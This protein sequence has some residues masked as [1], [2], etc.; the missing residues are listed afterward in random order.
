MRGERKAVQ[1]MWNQQSMWNQQWN[2]FAKVCRNAVDGTRSGNAHAIVAELPYGEY[3]S[4]NEPVGDAEFYVDTVERDNK[5]TNDQAFAEVELGSGRVKEVVV[6]KLDTG[7]QVNIIPKAVH[8]QLEKPRTGDL[9]V[10]LDPKDLNK[11][12]ARPHH[13][14]RTLEDILPVLTGAKYFSKLDARSAEITKPLRQLMAKDA[15]FLWDDAQHDAF[16]KVKEILTQSPVLAYFDPSKDTCL[17][18]DA[19]K[20]GL[21]AVVLQE[22]R[23]VAYASKS[24]T[25]TEVGYA[26]IEKELYAILFGCKRFHQYVYGKQTVV[27]TDHKPLTA[28]FSKPLHVAPPRLQRMLLQLQKYVRG[29]EIP[30]ADTLSRNFVSNT[31]PEFSDKLEVHVHTV[32]S[33]L[34]ISDVRLQEVKAATA[35]DAQCESLVQCIMTGWPRLRKDCSPSVVEFWNIRDE[36]TI[37]DGIIMKGHKIYIPSELRTRFLENIHA[38]HM[39]V[40]K[41]LSR[42]RDIVFWPRITAEITDMVLR[43]EVCLERRNS[44][45]KEPLTCHKVPEY[46]W[47]VVAS[48]LFTWEGSDY[49][50]VVDYYSRFFEVEKLTSTTSSCVINRLKRIF[51]RFG[52]PEKCVSDNGPQYAS[53]EF[54]RFAE[55]Y[56]FVHPTSSPHYPRSNG[57]AERTVQTVKRILSKAK[58]DGKDY[59]IGVLEYLTTPLSLG[60]SPSQLLMGRRLR[61]VVPTSAQLLKPST[62]DPSIVRQRIHDSQHKYKQYHDQSAQP[63]CPLGVGDGVRVQTGNGRWIPAVV[64]GKHDEHSYVVCTPDGA[65]YRRNRR[66]LVKPPLSAMYP[67]M[68]QNGDGPMQTSVSVDEKLLASYNPITS[69]PPTQISA[70]QPE[71]KKSVSSE[72]QNTRKEAEDLEDSTA[73]ELELEDEPSFKRRKN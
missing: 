22:G 4:E 36:L 34:P 26:Q 73:T 49:L 54:A 6:F 58:A 9:R 5:V 53:Q 40:E 21:G 41:C 45:V 66:H 48:D 12:I 31:Y 27:E 32:L 42:A 70:K 50:V 52:I 10:C 37:L 46:P 59:C 18:V 57:L 16:Q 35:A 61:S 64:S 20:Y 56:G 7:S 60:Y 29:T 68:K 55:Q 65:V 63:L 67:A 11:A 23:P 2:H 28:I 69:D 39:G 38:G 1:Q 19:S 51:C 47:Q 8:D 14:M 24:L 25:T 33:Y 30:V 71:V 43:C 15:V 3:K 17:Q 72:T 62:P 44:N 13:P